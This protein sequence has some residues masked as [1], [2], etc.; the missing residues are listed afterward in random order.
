MSR[1]ADRRG[2][3]AVRLRLSEA[4]TVRALDAVYA[5]VPTIECR[6]DCADTCTRF[7]TVRPERR[8]VEAASGIEFPEYH[9]GDRE[10]GPLPPCPLLT[11][12]GQCSVHPI[13]PLLCRLWGVSELF[14]CNYGCRVDGGHLL[15]VK[16]T[17]ALL[18][19][20]Y[21]VAGN[22]REAA[23]MRMILDVPDEQV[24]AQ[25]SL[26]KAMAWGRIGLSEAMDRSRE[27]G[28]F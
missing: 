12:A 5:Q 1:R 8:R 18:G 17:Y 27:R 15:G 22:H 28:V 7:P 19:D 9:E 16:E 11:W 23:R 13:R 20:V 3:G 10:R 6:G 4:A 25:K 14:P 2:S 24:A 21:E 26:L